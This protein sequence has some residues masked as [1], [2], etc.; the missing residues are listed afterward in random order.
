MIKISILKKQLEEY[1]ENNRIQYTYLNKI[2]KDISIPMYMLNLRV[3][4]EKTEDIE[5]EIPVI[6][7]IFKSA[8]II[9]F[10]CLDI[11]RAK[12]NNYIK[13][14]KTVNFMNKYSFPGKFL[15][16]DDNHVSYRCIIDYSDMEN[17][18][19]VLLEKILHSIPPAYY[20][21]L[22]QIEKCEKNGK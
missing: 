12:K 10:D 8:N 19:F 18:D 11:Y 6:L 1:L 3:M 16:D 17:L 9:F 21:L 7:T 14:L 2:H 4:D 13:I 5:I 20:I 15:I 22:E